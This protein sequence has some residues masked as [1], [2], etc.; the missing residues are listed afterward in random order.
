M[1][2]HLDKLVLGIDIGGSHVS[3]ALVNL[4]G[5]EFVKDSFSRKKIDSRSASGE[6]IV[7]DWIHTIQTSLNHLNGNVLQGIGIA[8]PGP[9]DYQEGISLIKG[10]NKYNALYG[11]NIKEILRNQLKI[12]Y[13]LPVV[14]ENDAS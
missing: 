12:D 10:V 14:F 13:D 7:D 3:S 9:F 2:K 6:S 8:M 5:E 1:F 11:I 4:E